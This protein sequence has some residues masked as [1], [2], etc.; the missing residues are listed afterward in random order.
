MHRPLRQLLLFLL[1]LSLL[2]G[3]VELLENLEHLVHDGHLAHL[4]VH[5]DDEA[6]HRSFEVEHGCT[7][8]HH[9]C[10]CHASSPALLPDEFDLSVAWLAHLRSR[11]PAYDPRLVTRANAPPVPPPTA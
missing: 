4:S 9:S 5:D 3:W 10:P 2:P 8:M 1:T 6:K 7:P 11:P